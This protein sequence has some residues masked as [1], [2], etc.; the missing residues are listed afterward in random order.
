ME[1]GELAV[2]FREPLY[3]V[4]PATSTKAAEVT[5]PEANKS[6]A[7]H[8]PEAPTS[9][10]TQQVDPPREVPA[11]G[12][13]VFIAGG[14]VNGSDK[15]LLGKILGAIDRTL[16]D[17]PLWTSGEGW[18]EGAVAKAMLVFGGDPQATFPDLPIKL[19]HTMQGPDGH[20]LWTSPLG[21]LQEDVA[22][23]RSLWEALK[24]LK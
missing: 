22:A 1:A 17:T 19:N 21:K 3:L 9:T 10:P 23:K 15:A 7:T 13:V 20:L 5:E 18:P 12:V 2:L 8:A 11:F 4:R 16:E 6:A 24:R 14:G